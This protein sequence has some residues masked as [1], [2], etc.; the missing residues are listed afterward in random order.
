MEQFDSIKSIVKDYLPVLR[1]CKI[2]AGIP[3][4]QY[5]AAIECLRGSLHRVKAGKMIISSGESFR[6]AFFLL[7][8]EFSVAFLN[9]SAEKITL[10][11]FYSGNL[12][13]ESMALIRDCVSPIEL[14]AEADSVYLSFSLLPLCE[15]PCSFRY[16]HRMMTNLLTALANQNFFLNQK[17]RILGQKRARDRILFYLSSLPESRSGY[18]IIPYTRTEMASFLGLNRS[19]MVRELGKMQDDGLIEIQDNRIRIL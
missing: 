16:Q 19:A 8:G 14:R 13:G 2:F 3:T 7:E 11:H 6:Y 5:P 17:V 9:E 15:E 12:M 18:R 10:N 1:K 4:D